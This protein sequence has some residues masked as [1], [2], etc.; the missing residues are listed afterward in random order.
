MEYFREYK[1]ALENAD[2][3]KIDFGSLTQGNRGFIS[4]ET[5]ERYRQDSLH[6]TGHT[7]EENRMKLSRV[8]SGEGGM[9]RGWGV[10]SAQARGVAES[11]RRYGRPQY[12]TGRETFSMTFKDGSVLDFNNYVLTTQGKEVRE[13]YRTISALLGTTDTI[14]D[15]QSI[16]DYLR[17]YFSNMLNQHLKD[18]KSM[19]EDIERAEQTG[20]NR[21]S[22]E[23]RKA[24][25][26]AKQYTPII[27]NTLQIIDNIS[28]FQISPKPKGN[29]YR[30]DV[31]ENDI[32]LNWDAALRNQ[33]KHVRQA[34]EKIKDFIHKQGDIYGIDTGNINDAKSGGALYME[35]VDMHLMMAL[36]VLRSVLLCYSIALECLVCGS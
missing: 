1:D 25:D 9:F 33:P 5:V 18:I 24:I 11:Y 31:P 13:I 30:L 10:Y 12:P 16:I 23:L 7:I 28:D 6:G 27:Q 22:E 36:L 19:E 14:P 3:D 20:R 35:I 26:N 34:I 2:P 17:N 29:I 8:G 15:S 32:I 4:D 21:T